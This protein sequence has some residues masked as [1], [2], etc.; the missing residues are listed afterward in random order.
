MHQTTAPVHSQNDQKDTVEWLYKNYWQPLIELSYYYLKDHALAEEI[1][2]QLF[3]D[4]F[5]KNI[6]IKE[7]H[8]PYGYLRIA[9][10][11][12]SYNCLLKNKRYK[13]HL[14]N[15]YCKNNDL[16]IN[17]IDNRIAMRD[18]QKEISF[19]LGQLEETCRTVFILNRQEN[20]TIKEISQKL[21]RPQ[22]TVTK[23]LRKAVKYL[24]KC[25]YPEQYIIQTTT[26]VSL[27]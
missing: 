4:I 12:R 2:Q 23:Q 3:I 24:H 15:L 7:T 20:M 11:N 9:V 5:R 14:Q 27:Q 8:N 10:K 16:A 1:V 26:P 13:Q 25:I 6:G 18:R 21:Q 19:Y 17:N 22:D